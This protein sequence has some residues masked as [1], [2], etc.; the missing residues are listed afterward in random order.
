MLIHA[1][2]GDSRFRQHRSGADLSFDV[3]F[4]ER[5]VHTH[6]FA[7]RFHLGA[8]DRIDT[9]KSRERKNRRFDVKIADPELARQSEFLELSAGHQFRCDFGQRHTGGLADEWHRSRRA[10]IHFQHINGTGTN[11]KL[12]IHQANDIQCA[13]QLDRVAANGFAQILFELV[14]RKNT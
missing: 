12:N 14:G 9:L 7:G 1:D 3:C 10:W 2:K 5:I 11:G 6:D 8:Q 4:A 13:A